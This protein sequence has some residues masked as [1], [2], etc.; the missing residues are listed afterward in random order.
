MDGRLM[1]RETDINASIDRRKLLVGASSAIIGGAAVPSLTA[2]QSSDECDSCGKI[3]EYDGN[4]YYRMKSEGGDILVLSI[5]KET[6]ATEYVRNPDVVTTAD[7]GTEE[8]VSEMSGFQY[9]SV[10]DWTADFT[11]KIGDNCGSYYSAH[12]FSGI[13]FET[14]EPINRTA[15]DA[16]AGMICAAL[17]LKVAKLK[18]LLSSDRKK[19]GFGGFCAGLWSIV[20]SGITGKEVTIGFWDDHQW[21]QPYMKWGA[22]GDKWADVDQMRKDGKAPQL[23][24]EAFL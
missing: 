9:Q 8:Y 6:G 1:S 17:P 4:I 14:A 23:H 5:D 21:W 7:I 15:E 20:R 22:A 24:V 16:V 12:Y 18:R 19:I 10:T 13:T 2:A 11:K 3:G